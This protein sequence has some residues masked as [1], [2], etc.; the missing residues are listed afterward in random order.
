M[1]GNT[2]SDQAQSCRASPTTL[3]PASIPPFPLDLDHRS[4]ADH[5]QTQASAI[6]NAKPP[7]TSRLHQYVQPPCPAAPVDH[8]HRETVAV[9]RA[10]RAARADVFVLGE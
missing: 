6:Q 1:N 7:L 5:S 8:R 9:D 2:S 10:D 4:W 3:C